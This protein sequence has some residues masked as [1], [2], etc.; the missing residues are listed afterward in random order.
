MSAVNEEY[1]KLVA[2]KEEALKLWR[3]TNSDAVWNAYK[4]A[5]KELD[6]YLRMKNRNAAAASMPTTSGKE[7]VF[8]GRRRRHTKRHAKRHTRRRRTTRKN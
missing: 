1:N 4:R 6:K 3:R 2:A 8:G 5:E 7:G